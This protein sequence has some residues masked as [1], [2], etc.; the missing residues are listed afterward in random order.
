MNE[1]YDAV[2]VGAGFGGIRALWELRQLGLSVACFEAGSDVGGAWYWNRYPGARTDSEAWIYALNFCPDAREEWNYGERYPSQREVQ[3]Y[4]GRV[5]D[6]LDLRKHIQFNT[7]VQYAHYS[8]QTKRWIIGKENGTS[9]TCRY[10]LPATGP[11][12]VAKKPP[13][14]GLKCYKGEWYQAQTWP[15]D[16]VDL[17]G[18]RVAVIGTGATGV[19]IV[20]KIAPVAKQLTVFQRTPNY[21]LPGRNYTI[22]EYQ[23]GEI[24]HRFEETWARARSHPSGLAMTPSGRTAK[25]VADMENIRQIFDAGWEA[26]G[27]HFNNETLDDLATNAQS[28]ELACE[29]LRQKIRTIVADPQ[30]AEL[31]CPKYPFL[32]KRPPCGH[33]YYEAFNRPN[34]KLVDI[35]SKNLDLYGDGICLDWKE[36]YEFD[37]IIFALGFDA[38]TGALAEIDVRGTDHKSLGASWATKLE[39]FAGVAVPGFPNMFPVCGPH[40]PFGNMPVVLDIQVDWIGR[41]I[42]H[43]EESGLTT[44]HVTQDAVDR[45]SAHV[46]DAF[47]QTLFAESAKRSGAW[48]VG[49][50]M[51][52]KSDSVL[53]YFG[54]VPSWTAWLNKEV[55]NSWPGLAFM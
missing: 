32:S 15:A 49:K 9:T 21:V 36:Q 6:R 44:V 19:Q 41:T 48:F 35:R 42:R 33:F 27:F 3:G 47:S 25:S 37:L 53:F 24:K 11:L 43:M 17:R 14:V 31:L 5:A 34:V 20:P 18:K 46:E 12:S 2:V 45:W 13:F 51:P 52:G 22:D 4:I 26:G 28:N 38:A 1:H 29:Y 23:A 7:R 16:T 30:T 54:G 55:D 50:N 40:V 8:E 39:T 10:F